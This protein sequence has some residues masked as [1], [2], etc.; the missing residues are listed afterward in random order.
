MNLKTKNKKNA[1]K[2]K[3]IRREW[4]GRGRALESVGEAVGSGPNSPLMK[5]AKRYQKGSFNYQA[6]A[7]ETGQFSPAMFTHPRRQQP[8]PVDAAMFS[9][10]PEKK[11]KKHK[12][13][14]GEMKK[15]GMMKKGC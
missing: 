12:K 2:L 8:V 14:H 7:T 5:T 3:D 1:S 10:M 13:E 6:R 15:R 4:K 11:L 9:S